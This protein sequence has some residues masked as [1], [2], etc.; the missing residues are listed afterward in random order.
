MVSGP[1]MQEMRAALERLEMKVDDLRDLRSSVARNSEQIAKIQVTLHGSDGRSGLLMDY[2]RIEQ[3]MGAILTTIRWF[4]SASVVILCG[5][6][7]K[8]ASTGLS[9]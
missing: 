3:Q 1:E 6:L 8:L 4:G 9:S 5:I 2:T 7:W